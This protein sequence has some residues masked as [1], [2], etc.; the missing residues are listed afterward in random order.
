MNN[1]IFIRRIVRLI[2]SLAVIT[3]VRLVYDLRLGLNEWQKNPSLEL[4]IM[5]ND[6]PVESMRSLLTIY[7][8]GSVSEKL[9]QRIHERY[10]IPHH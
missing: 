4:C 3:S 1:Y 6:H 9:W 10:F 8:H 5:D 7:I 2:D